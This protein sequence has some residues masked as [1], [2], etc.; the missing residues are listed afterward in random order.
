MAAGEHVHDIKKEVN[1]YLWVFGALAFL[2]VVTVLVSRLHF[3]L[4]GNITVALIIATVK[5][6]LV[7]SYFMHLIS[8]RAL[9]RSILIVAAVTIIGLVTL[10][11]LGQFN[12]I[13]GAH[14]VS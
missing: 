14:Y 3:G 2:T 6:S 13:A 12:I 5:A 4:A 8:E 11:L 10:L 7:A 9:I 1:T